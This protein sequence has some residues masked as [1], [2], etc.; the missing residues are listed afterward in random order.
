MSLPQELIDEIL[1]YLPLD[2]EHG[3]Q[4]LRNCSLV[5][6]SWIN[7]SRKHLFETVEIRETTLRSWY[8]SVSPANGGLLQHVRSLSYLVRLWPVSPPPEYRIDALRDYLPSLHNLQHLSLSSFILLSDVSQQVGP[9]SA[10]RHTLVRLS[11][12]QCKVTTSAL[13]TLINYFPHLNRLDLSRIPHGAYDK[14]A[15]PAS[16]PLIR[17]LHIF[18]LY[19]SSGFGLFHQLSAVGLAFD[20]I[21]FGEHPQ[22]PPLTFERVVGAVGAGVKRL[23]LSKPLKRGTLIKL[24]V[25]P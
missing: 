9:F 10:F 4:S 1:C 15:S 18:E 13:V 17:Q 6:R 11:L 23:R 7:P 25:A 21:V 5:A 2:G 12:S 19:R 24:R 8:D 16:R 3:E 22:I 20:E 14:P